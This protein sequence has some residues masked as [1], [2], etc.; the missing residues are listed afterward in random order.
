[1]YLEDD[2]TWGFKRIYHGITYQELVLIISLM[3][4]MD[5]KCPFY[6][7]TELKSAKGFDDVVLQREEN[8][9]VV[10][11][12]AQVK[13]SQNG[14]K[15]ISVGS[16]LTKSGKFN[17]LKYFAAYLKIKSNGKFKSEIKD[18][19]IATNIDFDFADSTQHAVRKLRMMLSG[20]NEG[21]EVS[22]VKIDIQDE[23]LDIGNGA[24][25]RINDS[26]G[27]IAQYLKQNMGFIKR[28]IGREV[29]DKE[30]EDFL[31]ELVFVVN[32]PNE[33][34]L[35]ELFKGKLSS[36]LA[37]RYGY[38]GGN[39]IFCNDLLKKISDWVKDIKGSFF[40]RKEGEKLFEEVELWASTLGKIEEE[41]KKVNEKA[42]RIEEKVNRIGEEVAD[43]VP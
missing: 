27:S 12:F 35:R 36:R 26:G 33:D 29:S 14:T 18:F 4:V 17:L 10:H 40:S 25:Y 37:E 23:F 34:Q 28:E 6:L 41:V 30:I 16:L 42:D 2:S 21:K 3:D 24:R 13:H 32:L 5:K 31:N 19:I 15:K 9:A 38:I 7:A 22:V 20:E 1:M 39:E 11:K 43:S 8:K